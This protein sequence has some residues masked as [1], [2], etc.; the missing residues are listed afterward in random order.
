MTFLQIKAYN[1]FDNLRIKDL[2]HIVPGEVLESSTRELVVSFPDGGLLFLFQFGCAVFFNVDPDRIEDCLN[3]LKKGAV[4]PLENPT[5]E[6]YQVKQSDRLHVEFD[7]VELTGFGV[8]YIRLVAMTVG[9]SAALEYFEAIADDLLRESHSL[10]KDLAG[11]KRLPWQNK[12]ILKTIG[13]SATARQ[14]II[15]NVWVLDP[16]DD[17]WKSAELEKLFKDLQQ[18]FDI[19]MRFK[20]LE[21][22]LTIVQDNNEILSDLVT[23]RK[24]AILELLIV[25]LIV[26]E[27]G[28]ALIEKH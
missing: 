23:S 5:F 3:I 20:T 1:S 17:T 8:E 28:L 6:Q 16:P 2:R 26:I 10:M 4:V 15:S 9:Q 13:T 22:K 24:T 7:F 19:D 14:R 12:K 11:G 27:I 18:N 21:K 25:I